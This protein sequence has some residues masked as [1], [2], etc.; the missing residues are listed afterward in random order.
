M[1]IIKTIERKRILIVDDEQ[2]VLDG[3]VEL[4]DICRI[5]TALSFD[6][7]KRLLEENDYDVAILDIMGVDGFNLLKIANR[8]NIPALML[9]AH[10]L[11]EKNLKQSAEGGAAYYAPKDEIE[12]IDLFVADIIEARE[13]QKN[14][15]VRWFER[16]GGYYDSRFAGLNWREKDK[17]FWEKKL[18]EGTYI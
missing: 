4:L 7:G 1:D 6:E 18:K 17:A 10:A 16:L 11:S 15:W 13:N 9:T 14:V 12:R 8:R 3:L 5:D 2:D